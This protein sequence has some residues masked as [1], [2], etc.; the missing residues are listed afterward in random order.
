MPTNTKQIN[1]ENI[2]LFLFRPK[3]IFYYFYLDLDLTLVVY[4]SIHVRKSGY[5]FYFEI[6]F[7]D[8]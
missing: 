1:K 6:L 8:I 4:I 2:L 5:T 3:K 7:D